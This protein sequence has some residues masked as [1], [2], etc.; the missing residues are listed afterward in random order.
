MKTTT[1]TFLVVAI[2]LV[3]H[4]WPTCANFRLRHG[5]EMA[6]Q[7]TAKQ[8]T[9]QHAKQRSIN[10]WAT[11]EDKSDDSS[12]GSLSEP[13]PS[14]LSGRRPQSWKS[15]L[16][17]RAKM[18]ELH[19]GQGSGESSESPISNT[20]SRSP[21]IQWANPS[22][23][24]WSDHNDAATGSDQPSSSRGKLQ[25][26]E[27]QTPTD[28]RAARP[29]QHF[30]P[31]SHDGPSPS[32]NAAGNHAFFVRA[33]HRFGEATSS[34]GQPGAPKPLPFVHIGGSG[35]AR[36]KRAEDSGTDAWTFTSSGTPMNRKQYLRS[37]RFSAVVAGA[38]LPLAAAGV[39]AE[40]GQWKATQAQAQAQQ[41][42]NKIQKDAQSQG[43]SSSATPA[44]SPTPPPPAAPSPASSAP[45]TTQSWVYT[46]PSGT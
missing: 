34:N 9:H 27:S 29:P 13:L 1:I 38:S 14:Q 8:T 37:K 4:T 18:E 26:S 35:P 25:S 11:I 46:G 43:R 2:T 30:D 36:T 40:I 21:R 17:K 39:V 44:P 32:H 45:T 5:A 15:T 3:G 12:H 41:E 24:I 22:H 23:M 28:K 31:G 42:G 10:S 16:T 6:L 20:F 7:T 33:N 19:S